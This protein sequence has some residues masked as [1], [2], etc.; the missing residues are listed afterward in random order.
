VNRQRRGA[1]TLVSRIR[2]TLSGFWCWPAGR[3]SGAVH[4]RGLQ[5]LVLAAWGVLTSGGR[6]RPRTYREEMVAAVTA[7]MRAKLGSRREGSWVN[8]WREDSPAV[9]DSQEGMTR[10]A[11]RGE[12]RRG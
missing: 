7:R 11:R 2:R 3:E 10:P 12:V 1:A 4:K 8:D 5:A 6:R 9:G